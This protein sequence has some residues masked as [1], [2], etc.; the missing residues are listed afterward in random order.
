MQRR[1]QRAKGESRGGATSVYGPGAQGPDVV[2]RDVPATLGPML[3]PSLSRER[4][5]GPVIDA[6][7]RGGTHGFG[8]YAGTPPSGGR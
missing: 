8:T 2:V 5:V 3:H 6:N 7:D 4:L 1:W